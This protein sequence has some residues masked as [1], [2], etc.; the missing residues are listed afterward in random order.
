MENTTKKITIYGEINYVLSLVLITL[1]VAMLA[2]A[3]YG[4]SFVVAPPIFLANIFLGFP[5]A[6]QGISF[7]V[8]SF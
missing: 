7:T 5:S 8:F 3:G 2:S 1:A 4:L 6:R